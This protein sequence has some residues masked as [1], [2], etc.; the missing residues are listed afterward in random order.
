MASA[1]KEPSDEMTITL[2]PLSRETVRTRWRDISAGER[3]GAGMRFDFA[4]LG[5][6]RNL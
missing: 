4:I 5:A 6:A 1:S 3:V 2:Q